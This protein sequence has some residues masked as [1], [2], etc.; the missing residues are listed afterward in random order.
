MR[1]Q[2]GLRTDIFL[3]LLFA[4]VALLIILSVGMAGDFSPF[5]NP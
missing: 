4:A 2:R 1:T 5:A 3:W